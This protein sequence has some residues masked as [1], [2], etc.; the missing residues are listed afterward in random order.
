MNRYP[1]WK[2]L[3]IA[4]TLLVGLLYTL[5]NFYGESPAIQISPLRITAEAGLPLLQK[6]EGT[7]KKHGLINEGTLVEGNSIKIR[8]ADTDV[9]IK[10]RDILQSE[11]GTDYIV[12]LNLI[13][14]SPEWLNSLGGLPM[15]LG[16]DLRGGVHFLLQTD[17]DGALS[18]ALDRYSSDIRST[19]REQK[20]SSAGLDRQD[21]QLIIKFRDEL[22]RSKAEAELKKIY[23]DLDVRTQDTGRDFRLLVSIKPEA[24][25]RM[26]S[27]TI[28]QNISTLR[29]RV[30]ELGVAEP[31][32]QQAGTDRVIVQLPGVQDTAKAKDILGRTATLEIRMVDDENDIDAALRG[33]IPFGTELLT[34]RDGGAILVKKQI[35]LTGD[36]ITDAQP[37]FDSDNQPAVHVTLDS[38]GARI[39]KQLTRNNVGKRMAILLV[40]KNRAEVVTAPVIREEIGG[41]RVQISGRMS[42][43]EARDVALLLR[44]GALA[45]PMEIIE[46]RTV[47]P[48]LGADNISRGFNSTLFGFLAVAIFIMLYYR[49]IGVISILALG[50]NLL[51]LISLLSIL[52]ATLTLPGMAAIALT[53]G[54]AID[55][56]V[57]INE[58]IRDEL[59]NGLT[60]Q[61]AISAGYERAFGTIVDSNITT[62][63]AGIALFAFGSGPVKGF[64]VVLCLG[65]LTSVFTAVTVSR[66]MVNLIYGGHRKLE[67]ISIGTVWK[68]KAVKR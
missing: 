15:Y 28:Q 9:Q 60:P 59:R 4:I 6:V 38:N 48:S 1:L 63:I 17:M 54:M 16:L 30:N 64:A 56:N 65:I 35:L 53:V 31:V 26:Q 55:A 58:R 14:N 67:K 44:A 25:T 19:L 45:A 33:Q 46:E 2:N 22:L 62:L 8:F 29:N 12:A 61:L 20:I 47:G 57:L 10:A 68:P 21:S 5:P 50:A 34:E 18:K 36:R 13:P 40:E 66:A 3:I 41:G 52:Q 51:L 43:M 7:L 32:I 39:F 27:A 23:S 49:A 37:G 24:Q 42:S 11:L